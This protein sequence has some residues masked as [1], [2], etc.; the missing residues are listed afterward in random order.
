MIPLLEYP[1]GSRFRA[2]FPAWIDLCG[3]DFVSCGQQTVSG[4][5]NDLPGSAYPINT[6]GTG[7]VFCVTEDLGL[8]SPD[9]CWACLIFFPSI[10]KDWPLLATAFMASNGGGWIV[11]G[12]VEIKI[13]HALQKVRDPPRLPVSLR[14][15][16][17][18]CRCRQG[19]VFSPWQRGRARAMRAP[20]S[21]SHIMRKDRHGIAWLGGKRSF[22]SVLLG[23]V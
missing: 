22:Q 4:R 15:V 2:K 18:D 13:R 7:L 11:L 16:G 14:S 19:S 17:C 9:P 6:P 12:L 23:P 8:V 5:L 20:T 10:R 3:F 21:K 1:N